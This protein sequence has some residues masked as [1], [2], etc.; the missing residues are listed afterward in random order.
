MLH[1]SDLHRTPGPR[2]SNDVLLAAMVSDARRWEKEEIPRPDIVVVSGDLIQGASRSSDDPDSEVS[3]QYEEA[4]EFLCGIATEFTDGDRSRVIVVPGNH[5]VHWTRAH[6]AMEQLATCPPEFAR[7]SLDP[8]SGV[9]WNWAEQKAYKIADEI[10]YQSRYEHFRRFRQEFYAEVEPNPLLH[11]DDSVVFIEY[12]TLGLVIVGFSSWHGNDCFCRV[13][14]INPSD[15]ALSQQLLERSAL[16]VAV[17]VWHHSIVGGPRVDDYM[18]QHVVHKLIDYG[19]CI[20]LHGHQHYSGAAPYELC[21]PNLTSMALIGAGSLAVGDDQLPVGES[22][23]YNIVNIDMKKKSITIHVRAM[24]PGG[25][26]YSSHR[27]D[28]LGESS[29]DL[30]LPTRAQSARQRTDVFA[31]DEAIAC[32]SQGL[33][34]NALESLGW[35]GQSVTIQPDRQIIAEALESMGDHDRLTVLLDPPLTADEAI[36]LI[37]LFLQS[38]RLDEAEACLS[39]IGDMLSESSRRDLAERIELARMML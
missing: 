23:Q 20:G 8:C 13:G 34:E 28:F 7:L 1:L 4:K 33:Y 18:D 38:D 9:R 24:S 6:N 36:R 17:A 35:E 3:S 25:V 15:L 32:V 21:L 22:R 26:F 14:D 31:R 5:D 19:F 37:S 39:S 16:P 10:K 11:T 27:D 29:I 2:L 30:N 12:P